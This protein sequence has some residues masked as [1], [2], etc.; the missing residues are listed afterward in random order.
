[1][2]WKVVLRGFWVHGVDNLRAYF[3]SAELF[4][5]QGRADRIRCPTLITMAEHDTLA[6]EGGAFMEALRCPKTLIHFTAEEGADGHC[7]MQIDHCSIS[8][9]WTGSTSS[10]DSRGS[11]FRGGRQSVG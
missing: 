11:L 2:N 6:A 7:S 5:M 10:S 1:M 9:C 3:A 4:S 8:V